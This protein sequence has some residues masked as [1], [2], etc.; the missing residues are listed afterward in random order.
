M[1]KAGQPLAHADAVC[2]TFEDISPLTRIKLEEGE[3]SAMKS[4]RWM[5]MRS[6]LMMSAHS[7]FMQWVT[8]IGR[9]GTTSPQQIERFAN[10]RPT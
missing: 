9:S 7:Q 10:W 1:G 3:W 6:R 8:V 4:F 2:H 5:S